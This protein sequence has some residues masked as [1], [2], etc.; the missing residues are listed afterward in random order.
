MQRLRRASGD[1]RVGR[2]GQPIK[3][4]RGLPVALDGDLRAGCLGQ[5]EFHVGYI[6]P[7]VLLFMLRR[8]A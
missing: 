2:E 3:G 8:I 7:A 4:V 5:G 6:P 1:G